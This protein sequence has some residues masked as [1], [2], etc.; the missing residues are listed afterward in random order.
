MLEHGEFSDRVIRIRIEPDSGQ[1][2]GIAELLEGIP[3][4]MQRATILAINDTLRNGKTV[5]VKGLGELL[6]LK[7]AEIRKRI[8]LA[9][10]TSKNQRGWIILQHL[11]YALK[12][13]KHKEVRKKKGWGTAASGEGVFVQI[14]KSGPPIR[15]AHAFLAKTALR[16][17]GLFQ[18]T[19][20]GPGSDRNKLTTPQAYDIRPIFWNSPELGQRL[21]DRMR[22]QFLKNLASKAEFLLSRK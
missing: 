5:I 17:F 7:Q 2:Q 11:R 9:L 4:G 20:L 21:V 22:S 14:E 15:F 16:G 1:V 13:F 12:R 3:S 8:R 6:T 10:A 19:T 18:R